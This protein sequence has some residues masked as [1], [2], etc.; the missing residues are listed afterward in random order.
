LS[1]NPRPHSFDF[2]LSAY[3]FRKDDSANSATVAFELASAKL[4]ASAD[5]A[6]K[7]HRFDVSLLALVLDANGEVV[8]KYSFEKPYYIPDANL[9][10]VRA[11][12]LTYTHVFD[13]PP[14]KYTVEAAVVDHEGAQATSE[15]SNFEIAAPPKG[16]AISSLALVEHLDTANAQTDLADPFTFKDKHIIP[17]VQGTVGPAAKRYIYFVVYQ[18]KANQAKPQIH[19]VFKNGGQQVADQTAAL[20]EAD[21]NGAITMFVT[22]PTRPGDCE[23][24][25]TALQGDESASEHIAYVGTAK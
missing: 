23:L 6:R 4:G 7:L 13:L 25:I 19:V 3:H 2:H 24:Q 1:T 20:P 12:Q 22:A 21:K 16:V 11:E 8:D 15:T 18:D 5:P 9:A 14:G 17:M 10:A